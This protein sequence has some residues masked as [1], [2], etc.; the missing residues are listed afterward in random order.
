MAFSDLCHISNAYKAV[1]NETDQSERIMEENSMVRDLITK[2][3]DETGPSEGSSSIQPQEKT[4][5][6][7]TSTQY[8]KNNPTTSFIPPS[9]NF[10]DPFNF[11]QNAQTEQHGFNFNTQNGFGNGYVNYPEEHLLMDPVGE[12]EVSQEQLNLLRLAAQE[13][14]GAQ[15]ASPN[16]YDDKYYNF[17]EPNQRNSLPETNMYSNNF[18]PNSLNLDNN[19]TNMDY[20]QRYPNKFD[21]YAKEQ[22]QEPADLLAYLN[23]LNINVTL[24]RSPDI[25]MDFKGQMENGHFHNEELNKMQDERNKMLFNRNFQQPPKFNGENNFYLNEMM[26]QMG[27]RPPQTF[28]F[29]NTPPNYKPNGFNQND[30]MQRQNQMMPRENF[31]G[32]MDQ[33]GNFEGQ[34]NAQQ[35]MMRQQELARQMNILMR[36]RPP[37]NQLNVDVSFL[38]E[39]TPFN[40]GLGALLGP[41]PPVPPP[42]L[43]S[44]MMDLPLLA[45]FY[46]MRNIRGAATSSGI[47]HARLDACYE[48][49]RQLERERKRTEARLALAYPGRA[50]SSSNSIPVPRLP[51]CPTRVDRLT[52]D[53][54]REH[55]K[56]LTLMGKMET[57]RASVCVA[58]NKKAKEDAKITVLKRGQDQPEP[59]HVDPDSFQ[60]ASWKDDVKNLS[61]IAPHSEVE[62]AM[63][64]W[65]SAVAAVQAARRRELAQPRYIRTDPILQL[66]EAVKQLGS[67]A[68]RARCAMWC[69]LT[70]T[71]ALAPAPAAALAPHAPHT[72]LPA[73][74]N[75]AKVR[76]AR[77]APC[78]ATSRSP[79]RSRPRPPPPSPRTPRTP[80]CP[81]APTPP[82]HAHRGARARARRRPRPAR[83][84]HPAARRRQHRQGKVRARCAMWCDLTLTVALAPAPAAALAPHTP[85]P[86]GANTAK[87]RFARAAPCGATS[88]SPW[89]SRPRA[90]ALAPHAPH[91]PHTPRPAGAN[92]AKG[93][94]ARAAPWGATSRSLW[95]SRPRPAAA[96]APHAPHTPLPAGANTAKVRFARAAPCGAT[97]R[98]PW[99]SRPRA[100]A[101]APHAPHAPHTP[102]PAGANTAKVRARCAMWCDLTLT[103]A[104]A[105]APAAALAPHAPHTPLPAG[106]NT[107]KSEK[108]PQPQ[109]PSP[110]SPAEA[111]TPPAQSHSKPAA[112]DVKDEKLNDASTVKTDTRPETNNNKTNTSNKQAEKDKNQR[113]TQ[114]Y[115]HKLSQGRN[116]F[117]QK[118]Q[119]YDSR[120]MQNRHPYY[121][122][123]G[124]IN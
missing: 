91:A 14:G 53:M 98:S 41:S 32:N 79:W 71:V 93:R 28:D 42:V 104:L 72:P 51:P 34:N 86:A 6:T 31:Q 50:V 15:F 20:A 76:F 38:H 82:S 100:A 8:P 61:E 69:D 4:L 75:T 60:P 70:L 89:R 64:S 66:A 19:F 81:P 21:N 92:T 5:S 113:K 1:E 43:P 30:F 23:Q 39:N 67:C 102:L 88:R 117:Y 85:L 27:D 36:N 77:A 119:R 90:A 122:A 97:S 78:G 65:R 63:L 37:P 107:A 10:Q 94:F 2:I 22:N 58:Q 114:N 17:F 35:A 95:R 123:T 46:A 96:L 87:V 101:L 112:S 48:Q 24:D 55:T 83:P 40:L 7:A 109:P 74:A 11:A 120:F 105:P 16:K 124:P 80:R 54:L 59:K 73:G 118:N 111:A 99:R 49:W 52:V 26:K 110:K 33:R 13:I 62:S 56:V 115:R 84:A 29:Q 108:Q 57:L 103:V 18:R 106:A 44:P 47:L 9:F 12:S 25:P 116:D 68:R 45:P 3:L 121:L